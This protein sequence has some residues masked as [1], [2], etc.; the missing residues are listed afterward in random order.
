MEA[1]AA[2]LEQAARSYESRLEEPLDLLVLGLGEDGHVASLFPGS[3]LL[4]ERVRRVAAVTDSPKP[5]ARRL[6]LTPRAIGEARALL[7]LASGSGKAG[8]VAAAFAANAD[9]ARVPAA[10]AREGE[11]VVDREAAASP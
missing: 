7:V 3:A 11:W 10:L 1:D 8:A 6:T 9:P 2:D 5:P 4:A